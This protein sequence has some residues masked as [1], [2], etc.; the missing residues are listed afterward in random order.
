MS[1][2]PSARKPSLL[3][4]ISQNLSSLIELSKQRMETESQWRAEDE[5]KEEEK[6]KRLEEQRKKEFEM[7][8]KFLRSKFIRLNIF[9][10]VGLTSV[11]TCESKV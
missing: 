7:L 2:A 6:E 10:Y 9:L 3:D 1:G 4:N 8:M 11:K 5:K